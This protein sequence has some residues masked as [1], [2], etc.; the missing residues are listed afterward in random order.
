MIRRY[1]LTLFC[2]IYVVQLQGQN[3]NEY[4]KFITEQ[5]TSA[6]DYIIKLFKEKDIVVFSERNH[7]EVEQYNLLLDVIKDPYFIKNVGAIYLEVC[8][9]NNSSPINNFLVHEGYDTIQ[10]YKET[11]K[12]YQLGN[13][14]HL[15]NCYSYPWLIYNLYNLNQNLPNKN[16]IHL[17]GCD[18]EFDWANY[19]TPEEY[20]TIDPILAVRDSLMAQNFIEQY[21]NIQT[22]RNGKKKALVIMNSRHGY[23]KDTHRTET[24]IRKNTGRYLYDKYKNRIASV[25]IMSP[26]HP[27]GW[28]KYELIKNGKWDAIFELTGKTNMGFDLKNTPFGKE[29]FDWTPE[30]WTL[31]KYRYEDVFTGIV[32]YKPL[33]EHILKRGWENSITDD[34]KPEFIRRMKIMDFDDEEI[35]NEVKIEKTV[36]SQ[37]YHNIVEFRNEIDSWK[38]E[39]KHIY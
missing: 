12:L 25:F 15:W 20:A 11:T 6:K 31:D 14:M 4:F 26:G 13:T 32:Y 9:V 33:E 28:D 30:G 5:K 16:K 19:K 22:Y 1:C 8:C 39:L 18:I 21:T 23:L 34:F 7:A 17:Y 38:E 2:I 37:Q 24:E 35:E 36:R 29:K 3:D 10:A 27:N